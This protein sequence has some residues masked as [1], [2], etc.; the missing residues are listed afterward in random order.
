[1]II[2]GLSFNNFIIIFQSYFD[3]IMTILIISQAPQD[4]LTIL[5]KS[6]HGDLL[7][8]IL[9]FFSNHCTIVYDCLSTDD[10]HMIILRYFEN[11]NRNVSH[12][13]HMTC[14]DRL[15][16]ENIIEHFVEG[17]T[18]KVNKFHYI[19]SRKRQLLLDFFSATILRLTLYFAQ[20]PC[21]LTM[22][23]S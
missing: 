2:L 5:L 19:F 11:K 21:S 3:H 8:I 17:T 15:I 23:I 13:G 10:C 20:V 22:V 9:H 4:H 12:D 7:I 6:S 1:M 14:Y 18:E 16:I